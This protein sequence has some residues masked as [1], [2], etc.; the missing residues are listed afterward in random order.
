MGRFTLSD[1]KT[2]L[3]AI[4]SEFNFHMGLFGKS[5]KE[6]SLEVTASRRI[7]T[8]AKV[9]RQMTVLTAQKPEVILFK[10]Q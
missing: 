4:N 10:K 3:E 7:S 5:D 9:E 2:D 1:D 8:N 6:K